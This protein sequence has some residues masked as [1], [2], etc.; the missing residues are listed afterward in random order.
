MT[1]EQKLKSINFK[2]CF[3]TDAG[4][5]VLADLDKFSY[6]LK[7]PFDANSERVTCYN[8]GAAYIVRYIHEQ[9][10]RDLDAKTPDEVIHKPKM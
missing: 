6:L 1:D 10:D 8:L 9:I 3:S 2:T 4:K 5:K 7:D